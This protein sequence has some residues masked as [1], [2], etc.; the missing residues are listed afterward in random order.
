MTGLN[1]QS[2]RIHLHNNCKLYE[3]AFID[4]QIISFVKKLTYYEGTSENKRNT[5]NR[6][7]Q[8]LCAFNN[9]SI[10]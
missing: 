9:S 8:Q 2:K 6:M 7:S 3:V 10:F 1:L 5:Y 4:S